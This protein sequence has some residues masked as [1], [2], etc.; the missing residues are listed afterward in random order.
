MQTKKIPTRASFIDARLVLENKKRKKTLMGERR[1]I[2][3]HVSYRRATCGK[4]DHD[5]VLRIVLASPP[6]ELF[7]PVVARGGNVCPYYVSVFSFLGGALRV[8]A[9]ADCLNLDRVNRFMFLSI[10]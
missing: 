9:R 6:A 7:Y 3:E 1:L 2:I 4:R 10:N 5:S 8:V